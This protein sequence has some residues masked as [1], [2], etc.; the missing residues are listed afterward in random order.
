[1]A[2]FASS[3]LPSFAA[4]PVFGSPN[5]KRPYS[6]VIRCVSTSGFATNLPSTLS[7]G[8]MSV[9]TPIQ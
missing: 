2:P 7:A 6:S 3:A 9:S 5:T 4:S 1:M 8:T